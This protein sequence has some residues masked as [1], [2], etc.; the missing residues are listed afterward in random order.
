MREREIKEGG[1][2]LGI[3]ESMEEGAKKKE[4]MILRIK[5]IGKVIVHFQPAFDPACPS[6]PAFFLAICKVHKN[7]DQPSKVFKSYY[8]GHFFHHTTVYLCGHRPGLLWG[9]IG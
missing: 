9:E 7:Q 6:H 1:W 2:G 5:V 8:S 4:E 3:K